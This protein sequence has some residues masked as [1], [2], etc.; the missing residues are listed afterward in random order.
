M[1][2]S[3]KEGEDSAEQ[4]DIGWGN[5]SK[6]WGQRPG[7]GHAKPHMAVVGI[8]GRHDG[9]GSKLSQLKLRAWQPCPPKALPLLRVH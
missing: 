6:P 8:G 3:Q 4:S 2:S 9:G 1:Q 7:P 5:L